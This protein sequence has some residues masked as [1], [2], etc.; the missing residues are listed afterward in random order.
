MDPRQ[1]NR[2][3]APTLTLA[4]E[5]GDGGV[6]GLSSSNREILEAVA[7]FGIALDTRPVEARVLALARGHG[8]TVHD[9]LYLELAL[10]REAALMTLDA[11]LGRAAEA[12]GVALAGAAR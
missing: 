5:A 9:A 10:R 1:G 6:P 7:G 11:A 12:E 3:P 8:L 4:R 2:P